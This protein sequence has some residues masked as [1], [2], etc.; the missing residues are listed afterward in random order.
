[1]TPR[2][3]EEY[4]ALRA[5]VAQRG[6]ARIVIAAAGLAL[7]AFATLDVWALPTMP[8]ITVVPLVLLG[9]AFET[10]FALHIGVERIGRY[11]QVFHE[12]PGEAARWEATA[13]RFGRPGAGTA[14]DPL[15]VTWFAAATLVNFLPVMVAAPTTVEVAALGGVHLVFLGRLIVARTAASKQRERDLARFEALRQHEGHEAH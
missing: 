14:L 12:A 10:V 7:W 2:E 11:V 15:F 5:T 6:T 13:M 8:L 3:L 4:K 1:M 9:A